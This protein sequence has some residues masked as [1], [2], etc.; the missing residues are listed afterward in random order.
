MNKPSDQ[1][2]AVTSQPGTSELSDQE[3][4]KV[5]GADKAVATKPTQDAPKESVTF[6][7]GTVK[8]DYSQQ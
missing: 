3:L 6:T 7:Y 2:S 4:D 8:I 1:K 5:T